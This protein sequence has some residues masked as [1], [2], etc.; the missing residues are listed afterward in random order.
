MQ[1]GGPTINPDGSMGIQKGD[2]VLHRG[3]TTGPGQDVC[4]PYVVLSKPVRLVGVFL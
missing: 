2:I 3:Q 1:N 4:E